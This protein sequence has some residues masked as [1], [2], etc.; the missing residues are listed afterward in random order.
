MSSYD[1]YASCAP[2][3][4]SKYGKNAWF[5]V[6]Y[7]YSSLRYFPIE[8]RMIDASRYV[9]ISTENRRSFSYEFASIIRDV[10][11]TFGSLLDVLVKKAVGKK[12]DLD[13]R[14]YIK[15]IVDEVKDVDAIGLRLKAYFTRSFVFPFE[16]VRKSPPTLEWWTTYNNL[17]H[18]DFDNFRDGCLVHAINGLASLATLCV[19]MDY[20]GTFSHQS[21]LFI[22][23]GYYSPLDKVKAYTF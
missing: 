8:R 14:D 22:E 4:H 20:Y 17:K 23:V 5:E 6:L 7:G 3:L 13:I 2:Q 10:G 11:S 21:E 19:L 16:N 1:S 9:E 15:F 18:S 12:G